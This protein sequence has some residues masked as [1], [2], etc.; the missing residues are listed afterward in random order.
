MAAALDIAS[1][2]AAPTNELKGDKVGTENVSKTIDEEKHNDLRNTGM[3]SDSSSNEESDKKRASVVIG[4]CERYQD[5]LDG[6]SEAETQG[7]IKKNDEVIGGKEL[8]LAG[9]EKSD[10]THIERLVNMAG[11]SITAKIINNLE[12]E[13]D[14]TRQEKIEAKE[15]MPAVQNIL[16][17]CSDPERSKTLSIFAE[18]LRALQNPIHKKKFRE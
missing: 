10:P 8:A 17:S 12:L 7:V 1:A 16:G 15:M 13:K 6:R 3:S 5:I 4:A 2:G 9:K 11:S 18:E 14:N